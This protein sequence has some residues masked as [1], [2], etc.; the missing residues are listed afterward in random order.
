MTFKKIILASILSATAL[1]AAASEANKDYYAQFNAGA[2]YGQKLKGDFSQGTLD[3]S[4]IYGFAVGYKFHKNFRADWS[5]DYRPG[6]ANS[7]MTSATET[8][9]YGSITYTDTH[10]VKVKSLV[11]MI[12]FYYDI[13]TIEKF[14]PYATFGLGFSQNKT[15]NYKFN[16][17][18]SYTN[19]THSTVYSKGTKIDFAWK[20]GLG[21]KYEINQDF[22]LDLHYQY[23]D[24]GKFRTGGSSSL[25]GKSHKATSRLSGRIKSHEV[26]LGVAYKF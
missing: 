3:N 11:S 15:N 26:T 13:I 17:K 22:D 20:I 23:A 5:L 12:N 16:Q 1:S 18:D 10:S 14:T 19:V 9:E 21:S 4:A 24:L 8:D 25:D 6:F 2:A 7:Y